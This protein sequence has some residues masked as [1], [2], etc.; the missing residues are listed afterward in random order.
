M[1]RK[2]E[3]NMVGRQGK[4]GREKIDYIKKLEKKR[5]YHRGLVIEGD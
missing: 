3:A 1:D 5:S 2:I 4:R